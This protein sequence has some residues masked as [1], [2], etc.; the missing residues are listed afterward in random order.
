[1]P[2]FTYKDPIDV[3][4]L[5]QGDIINRTPEVESI[6]K[7]VH[8]HYFEKN[9][10]K[11]FM[12]ITQ[13]C[14]LVK[15]NGECSSRYITIAA[16]RPLELAIEREIKRIQ[17]SEIE[18][19]LSICNEKQKFKIEQ[20]LERLLNNNASEYFFLYK[21]PD[22]GMVDDYCAFLRLTI[23]IKSELHYETLLNAKILQL[24][25]SF[26]HKL[27]YLV[28]NCYSRIATEDWAPNHIDKVDFLQKIRNYI[29]MVESV[30]WIKQDLCDYVIKKISGLDPEHQTMEMVDEL[31]SE[32]KKQKDLKQRDVL[33]MIAQTLSELDISEDKIELAKRRIINKPK[34]RA[35]LR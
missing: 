10:Y 15:R 27:G 2:H 29:D 8:P 9:D 5:H 3:D 28:G 35:S 34:F 32:R 30:T 24:K 22:K 33:E 14:D 4:S 1:M 20:F 7:K 18:K 26:Q 13:T 31:I 25:M 19:K 23:A 12:V 17:Y 16:V 21:E 11:F 6:I